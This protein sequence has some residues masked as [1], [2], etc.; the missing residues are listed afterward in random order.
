MSPRDLLDASISNLVWVL[1][2]VSI[3]HPY[4]FLIQIMA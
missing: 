4:L 2:E 3:I 1:D